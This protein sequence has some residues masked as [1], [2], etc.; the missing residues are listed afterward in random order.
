MS[1]RSPSPARSV[2]RKKVIL[3]MRRWD[4]ILSVQ[5][6]YQA[7]RS[8]RYQKNTGIFT[9]LPC[10]T[11]ASQGENRRSKNRR[12]LPPP[13]FLQRSKNQS[14]GKWF[15]NVQRHVVYHVIALSSVALT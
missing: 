5:T 9:C 12:P 7:M 15:D 4:M 14:K 11:P 2:I 10:L 8:S 13:P 6:N 3:T 1:P